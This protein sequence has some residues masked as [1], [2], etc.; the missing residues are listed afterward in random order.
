MILK[1]PQF[2]HSFSFTGMTEENNKTLQAECRMSR[3]ILDLG[4]SKYEAGKITFL[5]SR[6]EDQNSMKSSRI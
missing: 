2:R 5:Y 4:P 3:P 6:Y 1:L